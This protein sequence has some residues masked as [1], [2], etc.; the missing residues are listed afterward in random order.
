M[1]P[2][3]LAERIRTRR[4]ELGLSLDDLADAAG[5]SGTAVRKWESGE[6][7]NLKHEHL[8]A[9]AEAL[10][11]NPRW[12]ALGQ[13]QKEAFPSREAYSVALAR[14]DKAGNPKARSAWERIA[15]VFAKAAVIAIFCIGPVTYA[16][17][18][19]AVQNDRCVLCQIRKRIR[20]AREAL[21][22]GD[23]LASGTLHSLNACLVFAC[24]IS[25]W[26]MRSMPRFAAHRSVEPRAQMTDA[27]GC[28]WPILPPILPMSTPISLRPYATH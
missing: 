4:A 22:M 18:N 23:R 17:S 24:T 7:N 11:V 1:K 21:H 3:T 13:G 28:Y 27:S 15:L 5:V 19:A 9:I 2:T 8:F 25:A 6:T 16:P 12:L 10:N 14:R 20:Q 26:L